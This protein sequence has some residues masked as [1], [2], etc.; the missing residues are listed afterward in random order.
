MSWWS[1]RAS[2]ERRR[3]VG[4]EH[5]SLGCNGRRNFNRNGKDD[6]CTSESTHKTRG[7]GAC[8]THDTSLILLLSLCRQWM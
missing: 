7:G 5:T 1:L 6:D 3:R 8:H 4:T 2:S